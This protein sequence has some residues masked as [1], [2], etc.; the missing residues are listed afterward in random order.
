MKTPNYFKPDETAGLAK[1]EEGARDALD[2][3]IDVIEKDE[4]LE[5]TLNFEAIV[6]CERYCSEVAITLPD[7]VSVRCSD[8]RPMARWRA[9]SRQEI[10]V[11]LGFWRER[12][13]LRPTTR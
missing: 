12:Q 13:G 11:I 6:A 5:H 8:F 3:G 4:R 10:R 9:V 7:F 2:S 1:D